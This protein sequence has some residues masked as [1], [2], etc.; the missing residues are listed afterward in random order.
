MLQTIQVFPTP[1]DA[2]LRMSRKGQG[3]KPSATEAGNP[4]GRIGVSSSV[5]RIERAQLARS[6]LRSTEPGL[7]QLWTPNSR[8]LVDCVLWYLKIGP[9]DHGQPLSH[10]RLANFST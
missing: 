10:E 1:D 4:A 3:V 5:F 2:T 7:R 8:T 6:W 9:L